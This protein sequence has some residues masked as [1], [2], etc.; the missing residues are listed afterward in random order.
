MNHSRSRVC[1]WPPWLVF[2]WFAIRSCSCSFR[3]R[4][5]LLGSFGMGGTDWLCFVTGGD[6]F[7]WYGLRWLCLV[8]AALGSFGMA[9]SIAIRGI[10][11]RDLMIEDFMR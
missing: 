10:F 7:V 8:M 1:R 9:D 5:R 4:G 6:G 2:Q 3:R 11:I